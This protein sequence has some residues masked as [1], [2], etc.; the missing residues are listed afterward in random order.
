MAALQTV[1]RSGSVRGG[2]QGFNVLPAGV[3]MTDSIRP[4][5]LRIWLK[6]EYLDPENYFRFG[7][8][9]PE[10]EGASWPLGIA[11]NPDARLLVVDPAFDQFAKGACWLPWQYSKAPI[12]TADAR[13]QANV[14]IRHVGHWNDERHRFDELILSTQKEFVADWGQ[15]DRVVAITPFCILSQQSLRGRNDIRY[16]ELLFFYTFESFLQE[17]LAWEALKTGVSPSQIADAYQHIY[18]NCGTRPEVM[19]HHP[20]RFLLARLTN[21]SHD[22]DEIRITAETANL[23]TRKGGHPANAARA[24]RRSLFQ[25]RLQMHLTVA[26]AVAFHRLD[27]IELRRTALCEI[28]PAGSRPTPEQLAATWLRPAL[29]FYDYAAECETLLASLATRHG[30]PLAVGLRGAS[31]AGGKLFSTPAEQAIAAAASSLPVSR[32]QPEAFERSRWALFGM[33]FDDNSVEQWY[34]WNLHLP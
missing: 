16:V 1:D 8:K 20:A 4:P 23:D 18:S 34:R 26:A 27:A 13:H 30:N 3:A 2:S 14:V 29:G 15:Q 11:L 31:T 25:C 12:Q 10:Y 22:W 21:A 28:L 17:G 5:T 7:S 6:S 24:Y 19:P 9:Y 33:S 32:D